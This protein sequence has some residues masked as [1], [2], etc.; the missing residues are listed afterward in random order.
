MEQEQTTG[1]GGRIFMHQQHRS[2]RQW[3]LVLCGNLLLFA[4]LVFVVEIVL[5]FLGMGNVF[6]P[7]THQVLDFL[8]KLLF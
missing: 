1:I 5:I 2:V 7:W 3:V 8:N 4:G 6:L